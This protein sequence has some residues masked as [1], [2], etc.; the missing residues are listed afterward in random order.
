M[1]F[2]C[3]ATTKAAALTTLKA[4]ASDLG[5]MVALPAHAIGESSGG[6]GVPGGPGGCGRR[7]AG[8]G[9]GP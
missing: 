3:K 4:A 6:P 1:A 2:E 9:G 5:R 7:V 8:R